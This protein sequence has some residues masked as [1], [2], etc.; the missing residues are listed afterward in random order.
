M[1]VRLL[2][3]WVMRNWVFYLTSFKRLL[4]VIRTLHSQLSIENIPTKSKQN[5]SIQANTVFTGLNMFV[6]L[7]SIFSW[8]V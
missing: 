1:F 7:V 5:K 8:F 6:F 4:A 2:S 3:V